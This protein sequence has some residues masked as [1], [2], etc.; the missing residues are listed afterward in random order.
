MSND[1]G[2]TAPVKRGRG[3]P[4]GSRNKVSKEAAAFCRRL[5]KDKDYRIKFQ[6]DWKERKI[7][8]QIETLVW[9]YAHGKPVEQI[10]VGGDGSAPASGPIVLV[11]NGKTYMSG[12]GGQS[13]DNQ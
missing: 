12:N 11:V 1:Q 9:A 3:R 13:D 6:A 8:P 5:T 4:K 10:E 7:P 2:H